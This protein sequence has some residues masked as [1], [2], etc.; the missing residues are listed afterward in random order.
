MTQEQSRVAQQVQTALERIR[1]LSDAKSL[2]RFHENVERFQGIDDRQR[3]EL[4]GAIE[5]RLREVS[6]GSATK[7]FGPKDSEAREFLD[8][9]YAATAS[10]FDLSDNHVKNGVKTGGDML[11][12]RKHLDAYISYKNHDGWNANLSWLQD[13]ADTDPYLRV[14]L[15]QGGA[16][17]EASQQEQ[18][19]GLEE[20]EAAI[21]AYRQHLD[22]LVG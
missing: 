8:R 5:V 1:N 6:P 10:D 7:L 3:E 16:S 11:A 15:Y 12:G 9:V 2:L 21:S 4:L 13:N 18:R 14:W 19:F 17:N 22:N 20:R